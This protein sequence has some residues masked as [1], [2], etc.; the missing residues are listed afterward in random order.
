MM[1]RHNASPGC[2]LSFSQPMSCH[3]LFSP[4]RYTHSILLFP[5]TPLKKKKH[6]SCPLPSLSALPLVSLKQQLDGIPSACELLA[7]LLLLLLLTSNADF[8]LSHL[9]LPLIF[10]SDCLR[11]S[12]REAASLP[13]YC[14]CVSHSI[15]LCALLQCVCVCMWIMVHLCVYR[16]CVTFSCACSYYRESVFACVRLC[17]SVCQFFTHNYTVQTHIKHSDSFV[18]SQPE[19]TPA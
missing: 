12:P 2:T 9:Y 4:F 17:A 18:P 10:I 15:S 7:F 13:S 11:L 5:T 14:D 3:C 6:V 19:H 16:V 1:A 8:H